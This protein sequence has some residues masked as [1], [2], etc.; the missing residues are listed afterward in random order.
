ML[1][2]FTPRLQEANP[3]ETARAGDTSIGA[4]VPHNVVPREGASGNLVGWG[5]EAEGVPGGAS[6]CWRPVPAASVPSRL[7]S[8]RFVDDEAFFDHVDDAMTRWLM[9]ALNTDL[10]AFFEL[11]RAGG[12][13]YVSYSSSVVLG[14]RLPDASFRALDVPEMDLPLA[15]VIAGMPRASPAD[16]LLGSDFA[17]DIRVRAHAL[18]L[19]LDWIRRRVDQLAQTAAWAAGFNESRAVGPSTRRTE[20]P[21]MQALRARALEERDRILDTGE[22]V[23][24]YITIEAE[25][26][27]DLARAR[28][29]VLPVM[30]R[31]TGRALL[32]PPV[33]VDVPHVQ[34]GEPIWGGASDPVGAEVPL[35]S[36][37]AFMRPPTRSTRGLSVVD[38]LVGPG[39]V[40]VF[41]SCDI[42]NAGELRLGRDEF[43]APVRLPLQR[44][45]Q[46]L[47]VTG[48]PGMR[49]TTCTARLIR[50]LAWLGI[51]VVVLE[52]SKA[53]Y[54]G[55][56]ARDVLPTGCADGAV[57]HRVRAY[58][59]AI[60]GMQNGLGILK[61]QPVRVN[62]L[63]VDDGVRPALWCQDLAACMVSAFHMEEPPLPLHLEALLRRVYRQRGV[64]RQ[65]PADPSTVWPDV[66]D[67]LAEI[68]PYMK[69]ETFAGA[70][71]TANV[72]GA[73][74]RRV[75]SMCDMPALAHRT[76][77]MAHDLMGEGRPGASGVWR[78]PVVLELSSLGAEDGAFAGMVL[79][80]RLMRAARLL[81]S[82]PLHTV[83]V[84]EEAHALL[85]DR[86][87]GDPTLFARLY[88]QALA[89]LRDFGFGFVTV[90]Q[91]P[92]LLPAG[93]L[94][95]S[96][97]RVAFSS[98]HA[99]DRE[100]IGRALGLTD[101]QQR[102]L[103][104]LPAGAAV[105]AT[106]G[107][108]AASRI[109]I[110]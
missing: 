64:A 3:L 12:E 100:A 76:G 6:I 73:L 98:A 10:H 49:K 37:A 15:Q 103:S 60:L 70:E 13:A 34:H 40:Q 19:E 80:A 71:I 4:R 106:A 43:G 93:V 90:E 66:R 61:H 54:T 59:D 21:A 74:A 57:L 1:R 2:L 95:N 27:D 55:L 67:L 65:V 28:A 18:P 8:W 94:A 97:T 31:T 17:G 110:E 11:A 14:A 41:G 101:Y 78:A 24:F 42:A 77:I 75:R 44:I 25:H 96:V 81:G 5:R 86:I 68:D 107:S 35:S 50:Q 108:P 26:A 88:E 79:L 22:H 51:Q 105:F 33:C 52:P 30:E 16:E 83:V 46:H 32:T 63:A 20:D 92:S 62:P 38:A 53:E 56:L 36:A 109:D 72:R 39:S 58:G 7:T 45:A 23:R 87:S 48:Q 82:R 102:A 29:L 104:A 47:V 89:E 9:A 85:T 91:R 84:V 99:D 69:E